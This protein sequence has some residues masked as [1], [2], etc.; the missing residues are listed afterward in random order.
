MTCIN[1]NRLNPSRRHPNHDKL[2]KVRPLITFLNNTIRK[3]YTASVDESTIPF[4]QWSSHKQYMPLKPVKRGYKVW[5]LADSKTGYVIKFD[6]Y[7]GKSNDGC[8][9]NSLGEHVVISLTQDLK[10]S[11]SL[12]A[13]DNFVT[14]VNLMQMILNSGIYSI[15]TVRANWKGLPSVMKDKCTLKR[16]EFQF[17]FK[18]GTAVIKWMDNKTVAILTTSDN[19][20]D[21]TLVSRKNR[22]GTTSMVTCPTAVA[23]YNTIMGGVD[24]FYQLRER[25]A[26]GR[27]S[28]KWWHRILYFLLDMAVVNAF[29]M[30]KTNKGHFE[31]FIVL[32]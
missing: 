15:G 28:R 7:T 25:Y 16:G 22:G 30:Y 29:I 26:I 10:Y 8:T 11:N 12:V 13:F 18:R 32:I 1:D 14:K 21:T 2:H 20:S 5:Y 6:I 19:P 4:K 23:T 27:R 31:L 24:H 9:E 17:Q 3:P